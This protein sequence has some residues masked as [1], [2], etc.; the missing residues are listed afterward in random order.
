MICL[1]LLKNA[2]YSSEDP[3]Q[4]ASN[5]AGSSWNVLEPKLASSADAAKQMFRHWEICLC[6][7]RVGGDDIR[8]TKKKN[9]AESQPRRRGPPIRPT[10]PERKPKTET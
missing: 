3:K 7:S 9:I 8:T 4:N 5:H 1:L 2:C 6:K 10:S